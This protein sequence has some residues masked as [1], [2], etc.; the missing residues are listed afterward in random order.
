MVLGIPEVKYNQAQKSRIKTLSN[1]GQL[2]L[3]LENKY[4]LKNMVRVLAN[5]EMIK[6]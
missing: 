5:F 3:N 6:K 2:K 4:F 1:I